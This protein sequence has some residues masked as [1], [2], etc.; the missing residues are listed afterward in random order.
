MKKSS[1]VSPA[2]LVVAVLFAAMVALPL[3]LVVGSDGGDLLAK[4][5]LLGAIVVPPA[6]ALFWA[7]TRYGPAT[8]QATDP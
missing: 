4:A 5:L 6:L 7:Q 2:D 8:R 1:Q 3:P